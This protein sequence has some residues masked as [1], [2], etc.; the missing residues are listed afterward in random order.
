MA[1][2]PAA[3]EPPDT[4]YVPLSVRVGVDLAGPILYLTDRNNLNTEAFISVDLSEKRTLFLS[5]GYSKY[6]YTQY[7]YSFNA[8]GVNFKAGMDFNLL[9]PKTGMGMYW[10]G[11][12]IHYGLTSFGYEIPVISHTNYWGSFSSTIPSQRGWAHFVEITPGFRAQLFGNI[13]LGWSLSLRKMI[14]SGVSKESG[15]IYFPGYGKAT[16]SFTPGINYYITWNFK[17][18]TIR[19]LIQKE[20]PQE[21]ESDTMNP[22][23]TENSGNVQQLER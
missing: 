7:N 4:V 11:I 12:G 6:A 21:P 23:N 18:K 2:E 14:Y 3:V 16:K 13:S 9:K 17:Y 20:A 22:E 5:G 10:A 1:Q 8:K 15:P 19:V